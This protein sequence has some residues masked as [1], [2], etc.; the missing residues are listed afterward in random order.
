MN[1]LIRQ[2]RD[3][4]PEEDQQWDDLE[5]IQAATEKFDQLF[6]KAVAAHCAEIAQKYNAAAAI[7]IRA[8]F[9]VNS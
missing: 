5:S 3:S 1:D 6:A 7:E 4:I 2:I 8:R 9:G